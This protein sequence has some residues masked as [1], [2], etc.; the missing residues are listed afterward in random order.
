MLDEM[1]N[2]LSEVPTHVNSWESTLVIP[3]TYCLYGRRSPVNEAA[4]SFIAS[5]G[6]NYDTEELR[7]K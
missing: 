4:T 1:Q 2:F 7:R 3:G 5:M 6:S